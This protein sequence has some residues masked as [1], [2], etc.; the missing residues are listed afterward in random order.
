[1][2]VPMAVGKSGKVPGFC[3]T[4]IA[5]LLSPT[6]SEESSVSVSGSIAANPSMK[7]PRGC[8]TETTTDPVTPLTTVS[9]AVIRPG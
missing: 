7:T 4:I 8:V 9:L 6:M 2:G 5:T 1:M 3:P